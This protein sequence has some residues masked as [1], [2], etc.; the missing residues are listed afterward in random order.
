MEDLNLNNIFSTNYESCIC[1][2]GETQT[3]TKVSLRTG[4][5][6]KLMSFNSW[7]LIR[8]PNS[9]SEKKI[10]SDEAGMKSIIEKHI[11][12][13]WLRCGGKV[14]GEQYLGCVAADKKMEE[15]GNNWIAEQKLKNKHAN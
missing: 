12:T 3:E 8:S 13:H 10:F 15:V 4:K 7:L 6:E 2:V 1:D 14:L 11:P 5:G 9:K